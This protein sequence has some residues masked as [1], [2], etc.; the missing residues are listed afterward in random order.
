MRRRGPLIALFPSLPV[1]LYPS[2]R[3]FQIDYV[4][5]SC[6]GRVGTTL[7][8]SCVCLKFCPNGECEFSPV[9]SHCVS[10]WL[11]SGTRLR[12]RGLGSGSEDGLAADILVPLDTLSGS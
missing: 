5:H 9:G 10:L 6:S 3:H 4:M 1:P 7:H 2:C 8:N 12:H 11:G